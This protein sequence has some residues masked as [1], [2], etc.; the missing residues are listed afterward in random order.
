MFQ[1]IHIQDWSAQYWVDGGC[2][3]EV[4]NV[5]MSVYGI[6]YNLSDSSQTDVGAPAQG[7]SSPGPIT[8]SAGFMAYYEVTIFTKSIVWP[9]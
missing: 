9:S 8:E 6:G 3:L 4:L 2:P 1:Y 5:G 7:P